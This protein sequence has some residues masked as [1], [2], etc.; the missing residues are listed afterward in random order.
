[1]APLSI[2]KLALCDHVHCLFDDESCGASVVP[3]NV[4]AVAR[5]K[6]DRRTLRVARTASAVPLQ[7]QTGHISWEPAA[8]RP[9]DYR[10]L[11]RR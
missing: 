10:D 1:M 7:Y 5:F 4:Y 2:E 6:P 3:V 9:G 8:A 11:L